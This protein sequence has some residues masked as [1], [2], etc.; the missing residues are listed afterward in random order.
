MTGFPVEDPVG[1]VLFEDQ[2]RLLVR[3]VVFS[4]S[5]AA[6]LVEMPSFYDLR[7]TNLYAKLRKGP[8]VAGLRDPGLG[9]GLWRMHSRGAEVLCAL[10]SAQCTN[11]LLLMTTVNFSLK[12]IICFHLPN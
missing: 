2:S 10:K 11:E 7:L 4:C 8:K 6:G 9:D 1:D 3:P 5:R 12:A